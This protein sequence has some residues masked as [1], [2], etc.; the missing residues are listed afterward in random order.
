M[1]KYHNKKVIVDGQEF[2]SKVEAIRWCDLK[3]LE[4]AGHISNLERQ[5]EFV[6]IPPQSD[7]ETG[8]HCERAVK[9]VAD[10]CYDNNRTGKYV[11]EDVKSSITRK[12]KSYIIKRKLMLYVYGI[13]IREV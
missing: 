8:K 6:L 5:V 10:F 4:R 13:R 12:E 1:S 11:V 9:Y 7:P 3:T 2:D